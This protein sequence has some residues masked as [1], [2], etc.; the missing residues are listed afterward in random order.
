MTK[1]RIVCW[2]FALTASSC[3]S[4][5]Q[6]SQ[7]GASSAKRGPDPLKTATQPLTP[8]SAMPPQRQPSADV[9]S[10]ASSHKTAMELSHLERQNNGAVSSNSGARA[11]KGPSAPKSADA[12]AAQDPTINFKYKKPVGGMQAAR[13]DANTKNSSTPR[14]KKN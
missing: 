9:P 10:A 8:K 4:L 3:L 12:S 13:P 6:S 11:A 5:A 7:V 2:F 14:V 1:Y